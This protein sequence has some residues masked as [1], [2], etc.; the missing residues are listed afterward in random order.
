VEQSAQLERF[1][2]LP[3]E[4]RELFNT[5]DPS[6]LVFL[7]RE[8][9]IEGLLALGPKDSGDRYRGEDL[10]LLAT[11]GDHAGTAL[12]SSRFH[13][14][15]LERRRLEEELSVARRIQ[16]TLLP[17]EVPQR[18]GVEIAALTR[19]CQAVGG[20]YYDFLDFGSKGL[21]LAVA[22]VSGK[23]VPAAL[24]LSGLQA[25]LR[26]EAGPE[27]APEPVVRRI[28]ERLCSHVQPGSFASL[29]YG[30][31]DVDER[32]FRYVN[33]GHPAALIVRRDG[34]LE[35]LSEG[36]MLLGVE[37][38]A[39][40]C[41]G[42]ERLEPGD[43]LLLYSDGVT[44]VLNGQDEE[45]GAGRLETLLK[46]IAHLPGASMID[47]IVAS[48]ESFVGGSVPDDIT[49]LVAKFLPESPRESTG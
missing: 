43:L 40:Y 17:S 14:E 1:G 37:R 6:V 13:E 16:A 18:R 31:L 20:D 2:R 8:R 49:L 32:S 11:L 45:Y 10:E 23:G 36:G 15:A 29:V 46:R 21:G 41:T 42:H 26:A 30:H 24:I 48:V 38:E 27:H 5:V 19:P 35:R 22:D 9:N 28:N 7:P 44:D 12:S 39:S 3:E 34:Q 47:S 4:E 25:T 33:A